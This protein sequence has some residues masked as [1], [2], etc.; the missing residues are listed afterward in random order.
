M[1]F[2]FIFFANGHVFS[3]KDSVWV[4]LTYTNKIEDGKRTAQKTVTNQKTFTL[5]WQLLREI[6]LDAETGKINSYIVYFYDKHNRL[7]SVEEF[8]I[9]DSLINGKK[10]SYDLQNRAN[11]IKYY[12]SKSSKVPVLEK[13][14]IITY[15]NDTLKKSVVAF[16]PAGKRIYSATYKY[17]PLKMINTIVKKF[18][19]SPDGISGITELHVLNDKGLVVEKNEIIKH[20]QGTV[21]LSSE[22]EYN[23]QGKLLS[24]KKFR[25]GQPDMV[26]NYK[27][28]ANNQLHI[29]EEFNKDNVLI[30]YRNYDYLIY[31]INLGS[32]KSYLE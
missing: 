17:N 3:Q 12:L 5:N 27:Y 25:N 29:I 7:S 4:T 8:T 26:I 10:F 15:Y 6:K 2:I 21:N 32:N 30:S 16:N 24:E 11:E 31:Y 22:F 9:G 18:R 14:E 13:R 19:A 28:F 1:I 23:D 20:K